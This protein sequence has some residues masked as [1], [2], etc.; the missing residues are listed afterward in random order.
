VLKVLYF[1][2]RP[3]DEHLREVGC[4]VGATAMVRSSVRTIRGSPPGRGV[5]IGGGGGSLL[6]LVLLPLVVV[7][8]ASQIAGSM[9]SERHT[10]LVMGA[11]FDGA[12]LDN[13]VT[14]AGHDDAVLQR[15]Q[16]R[17][18]ELE[19]RLA[20]HP[21]EEAT[22]LKYLL[23]CEQTGQLTEAMG[24][25]KRFLVSAGAT[26]DR[27]LGY[28]GWLSSHSLEAE[29]IAVCEAMA[30]AGMHPRGYHGLYGRLLIPVDREKA[31]AEL[32]LALVEEPQAPEVLEALEQLDQP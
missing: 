22:L 16:A 3:T 7:A 4:S 1:Q 29:A 30:E 27:L 19:A 23:A 31:R 11:G 8:V 2:K 12:G 17:A 25:W 24:S 15:A 9:P 6:D 26:P 14:V 28:A 32:R 21:E 20:E 10:V 5:G 13:A 18:V